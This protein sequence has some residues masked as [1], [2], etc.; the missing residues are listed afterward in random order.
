M[1]GSF[2]IRLLM[3]ML[4]VTL[5][6]LSLQSENATRQYIEPAVQFILKDYGANLRLEHMISRLL[7]VG[8]E[9]DAPVSSSTVLQVPCEYS[10]IEKKYGWYWNEENRKQEFCPGIYLQVKENS[11]VRPVLPG[12]VEAISVDGKEKSVLIKHEGD[13]YSYYEGLG[14]VLVSK[15]E[16]V[17]TDQLLGRTGQRLYFQLKNA[18]G[19]LNPNQLFE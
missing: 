8:Q 14:E 16:Q 11:L 5:A 3:V 1:L 17:N 18:E 4:V 6:G 7:H 15:S 12:K 10:S 19:P 13:L 9:K 2:R